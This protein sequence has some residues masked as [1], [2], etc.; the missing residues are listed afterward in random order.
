M[1]HQVYNLWNIRLPQSHIGC[2]LL[3]RLT[4][5]ISQT[6]FSVF[7]TS[8]QPWRLSKVHCHQQNHPQF[9]CR[10]K[11]T[12]TTK[13]IFSK[14]QSVRQH[15]SSASIWIKG[16]NGKWWRWGGSNKN[17]HAEC[18]SM[19]PWLDS[20]LLIY[21]ASWSDA[22]EVFFFNSNILYTLIL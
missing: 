11:R 18:G 19:S 13:M 15:P 1:R 7:Y 20:L 6:G 3:V 9:V 22:D 12:T 4:Q 5:N 8:W 14:N 17:G 16:P 2:A 10:A 21:W